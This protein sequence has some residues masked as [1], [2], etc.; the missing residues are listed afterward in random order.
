MTYYSDLGF[1]DCQVAG[2]VAEAAI[3]DL[4]V[5]LFS[6]PGFPQIEVSGEPGASFTVVLRWKKIS[7]VP[8]QLSKAEASAAVKKFRSGTGDDSALFEKVQRAVAELEGKAS[9]YPAVS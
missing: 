3:H 4:R 1:S 6:F 8:F 2:A 7:S 5:N 9:R